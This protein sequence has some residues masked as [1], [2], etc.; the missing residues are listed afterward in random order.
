MP[1]LRS[2]KSNKGQQTSARLDGNGGNQI[3]VAPARWYLEATRRNRR[4]DWRVTVLSANVLAG[5]ALAEDV[6][7]LG[8]VCH[9]GGGEVLPC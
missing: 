3:S 1:S 7:G 6:D 2:I 9:G 5:L 4:T 8:C